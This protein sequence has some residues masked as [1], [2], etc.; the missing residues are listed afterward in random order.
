MA[1]LRTVILAGELG[2]LFGRQH[3][4]AI[5]TPAEAIRALC[6]NFAGFDKHLIDSQQRGVA[7]KVTIDRAPVDG[8]LEGLHQPYSQTLRIVP[9]V[10]G[11]KSGF[12][13]VVLGAA[14]IG[15]SFFLPGAALFTVGTFAP[16]L[17]SIAFGLGASLLLG[18]VSQ[19]LAVQPKAPEPSEQPENK[20]SYSFNGAVNTTAQG[21]SVPVCYGRLIVGSAV[22]SAGITADD[23]RAAGLT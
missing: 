15:A 6:A 2:R 18:G 7:Y 5:T 8:Q 13:G 20:P 4:F 9:V 22:I 12:L 17:A 11:G 10:T 14:L 21:Q 3:R 1:I 23:Y 16:S 19:M